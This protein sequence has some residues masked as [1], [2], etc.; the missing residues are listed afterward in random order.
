M[1]GMTSTVSKV[2]EIRPKSNEIAS[3]WKIGSVKI[4][5]APMIAARAVTILSNG[6]TIGYSHRS[7]ERHPIPIRIERG[8]GEKVLNEAFLTTP[9]PA[10]VIPCAK[11]VVELGDVVRVGEE[12]SSFPIFRHNGSAAEMVTLTA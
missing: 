1:A 4:T 10:N 9:I 7:G 6:K 11:G 3:P 12:K 8:K 2:D 5:A